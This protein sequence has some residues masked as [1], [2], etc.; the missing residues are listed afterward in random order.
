MSRRE[1]NYRKI[2]RT[3]EDSCPIF[4]SL[5]NDDPRYEKECLGLTQIGLYKPRRRLEA[6]NFGFRKWRDCSIY[7]AKIK[8]LISC[9]APMFSHMKKHILKTRIIIS[10]GNIKIVLPFYSPKSFEYQCLASYHSRIIFESSKWS[11][12]DPRVI[13]HVFYT[14]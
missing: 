1:S 3:S 12:L 9:P 4:L 5:I 2:Y 13:S 10:F 7:V 6:C 14:N 8:V 11:S